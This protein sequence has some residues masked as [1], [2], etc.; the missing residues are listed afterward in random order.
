M[1]GPM[2]IERPPITVMA[3]TSMLEPTGNDDVPMRL[4]MCPYAAP[5]TPAM[6]PAR[7]KPWSF[8]SRAGTVK[9]RALSSL[10]RTATSRR[11]SPPRRTLRA[12][13]ATTTS[14]AKT[15]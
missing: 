11:P 14:T 12:S 13:S 10:S 9:A 15:Q 2:R 4:S 7:R 6:K 1:S 8:T 5:P 3:T